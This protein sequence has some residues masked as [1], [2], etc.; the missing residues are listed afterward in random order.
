MIEPM[1]KL[2][3]SVLHEI[4]NLFDD[5]RCLTPSRKTIQLV[6]HLQGVRSNNLIPPDPPKQPEKIT[7][8]LLKKGK[9]PGEGC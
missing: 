1:Y 6:M 8:E 4:L 3:E 7:D 5:D 2:P 9:P